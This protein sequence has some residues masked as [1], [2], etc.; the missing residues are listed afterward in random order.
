VL[1]PILHV[2]NG[3]TLGV[4]GRQTLLSVSHGSIQLAEPG[5]YSLEG[6]NGSGKSILIR[7][8]TG[9]LPAVFEPVELVVFVDG[10]RIML[11]SPGDALR[12]GVITVY[13]DD[14]L[15]SSMTV[16]DQILL[17]HSKTKI[18]DFR[19][20]VWDVIYH[21]FFLWF[22][23]FAAA[24]PD[25]V[26]EVLNKFE[27]KHVD[28]R[29]KKAIRTLALEFL[30]D[31]GISTEVLDE[32]PTV[33]SGG[34]RAAAKLISAQLYENTRVLILDE[35]LSGVSNNIWPGYVDRLREW[36]LRKKVAVLVV[37]HNRYELERWNPMKRFVIHEAK[38]GVVTGRVSVPVPS[39]DPP[40]N[41]RPDI[42]TL[43]SDAHTK[44]DAYNELWR[45]IE[46][47]DELLAIVDHDVRC[48]D[49]WKEFLRNCPSAPVEMEVTPADINKGLQCYWDLLEKIEVA[50]QEK[51][52]QLLVA[53]AEAA[54]NWGCLLN[55]TTGQRYGG[56]VFVP[57]TADAMAF[58]LTSP[59]ASVRFPE[60]GIAG[61]TPSRF[62]TATAIVRPHAILLNPAFLKKQSDDGLRR[63]L[64]TLLRV[65][66]MMD[67][68]LYLRSIN[69]LSSSRLDRTEV[70]KLINDAGLAVAEIRGVDTDWSN[71]A[72][73]L[74]YGDLHGRAIDILLAGQLRP[75][76]SL[77]LGIIVE[78]IVCGCNAHIQRELV[79]V[80]VA[81]VPTIGEMLGR[82][83]SSDV[84]A[85]YA[86]L[87][88]ATM[89]GLELGAHSQFNITKMREALSLRSPLT[90][91]HV[92]LDEQVSGVIRRVSRSSI[93]AGYLQLKE[94]FA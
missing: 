57:S 89:S 92:H 70:F 50:S 48:S 34:T 27:P 58:A 33:L 23:V 19:S 87:C 43:G 40:A 9:A 78:G 2:P 53:G 63:V 14:T 17:R 60:P 90:P 21:E 61:T 25:R 4:P 64:V 93:E 77:L 18:S 67:E 32:V 1:A 22:R 31:N 85:T 54:I 42:F 3:F 86:K 30:R 56:P 66:L 52:C 15:I 12:S 55:S 49:S 65:G 83:R 82:L 7:L 80:M 29:N 62:A 44:T 88:G 81:M 71:W 72:R 8:L 47:F 46:P 45:T 39:E 20:F 11:K 13:Q 74:S 91:L 10:T 79:R 16:Y 28:W 24:V 6:P 51:R 69:Q 76:A 75:G 59:L 37:T 73:I 41:I 68:P 94:V 38:L 26:Q 35:A 36:A 5:I 84:V